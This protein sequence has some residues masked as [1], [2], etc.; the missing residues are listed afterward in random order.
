MC[1][2]ISCAINLSEFDIDLVCF[3]GVYLFKTTYIVAMVFMHDDDDFY[4][5]DNDYDVDND[6]DN[7]YDYYGSGDANLYY[8]SP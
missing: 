7:D 1:N 3:V 4:D 2:K 5:E 8:N 6:D